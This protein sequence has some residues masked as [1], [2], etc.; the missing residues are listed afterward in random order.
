MMDDYMKLNSACIQLGV[1]ASDWQDAIRKT[2]K[3]L[4][5]N[6]YVLP[7]YPDDVIERELQWATG[8]PTEPFGVAIPH[9]LTPVNVKQAQIAVSRLA[10]PVKFR[11][12][13]GTPGVDDLDCSIVF[14]LALTD[15]QSQ[16]TLL[17]SLMVV[18]SDEELLV[19]LLNAA[20]PQ[21]SND[22]FT[23]AS[24]TT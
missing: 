24:A 19:S 12:S 5:E 21:E 7:G 17:Q 10:K 18:I 23:G 2:C 4:I 20:S 13:G 11:Q 8:L 9:A 15:P 16:L 1:E 3:P 14:V 6:G 22:I